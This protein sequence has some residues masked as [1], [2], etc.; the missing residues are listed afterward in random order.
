[1]S[2]Y[3]GEFV[4]YWQRVVGDK[5]LKLDLKKLQKSATQ[6]FESGDISNNYK[7]K[8]VYNLL[9]AV[10]NKDQERFFYILLKAIN[11]PGKEGFEELWEELQKDYDLMP[12]EVFINFAYSIILGIMK[13]YGGEKNG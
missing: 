7:Q 8:L 13:T 4:M 9:D 1:M 11:K 6:A 5:D 12:D 3:E 10:K 2:E